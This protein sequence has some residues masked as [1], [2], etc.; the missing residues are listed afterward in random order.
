MAVG[1]AALGVALPLP[2]SVGATERVPDPIYA[3]IELHRRTHVAHMDALTLQDRLERAYDPDPGRVSEKPCHDENDAFQALV[4][5]AATTLPGL[6][7]WLGYL[8]DLASK[9]ET[10]WMMFDRTPAAVVVDS[11]VTSLK[12]IGV[13]A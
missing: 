10:E 12:N 1:G 9:F 6:I 4:A 13:Q 3:A 2:G 11:F 7:A 5:A 8:Q